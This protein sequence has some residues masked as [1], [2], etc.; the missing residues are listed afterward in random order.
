MRTYHKHN[1]NA[2][3]TIPS[4]TQILADAVNTPG[5]MLE[6]YTAFH[7]YSI[8]NQL[9]ALCQCQQRGI[10]PGAIK[11]FPGWQSLG[12]NVKRGERALV[13]C[14]PVTGKRRERERNSEDEPQTYT[15]FAYKP[16]WFVLSQTE[17]E[18]M[19]AA[20]IPEYS[21]ERALAALNIERIPFDLM[22]GNCQGFARKRQIAINPVAQ[23][24]AKTFF[25]EVAHVTIGHTTQA[26]FTDSERTPKN[27][28]E[29]EAEAVAL[30]C[31][32]SLGLDGAPYCRGY[33]QNWLEGER[34][35]EQSAQKILR[36]ADQILRAGREQQTAE[37]LTDS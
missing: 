29:V 8:G 3:T 1:T 6:A 23:L 26:D 10:Q 36:A 7:D 18:E 4:W 9:L 21:C 25:H 27:L 15:A 24:T 2:Q 37:Q 30:L 34:L 32:E 31:C 14:M 13:L 12:R 19:P 20:I 33:I 5:R 22:D 16:R 35:P 17:G 28:R 11:T